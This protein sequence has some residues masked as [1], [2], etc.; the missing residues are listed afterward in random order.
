MLRNA[1]TIYRNKGV[2]KSHHYHLYHAQVPPKPGIRY[3][4]CGTK[5]ILSFSNSLYEFG[6]LD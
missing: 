4:L 1:A 2:E 3:D 6:I 5:N